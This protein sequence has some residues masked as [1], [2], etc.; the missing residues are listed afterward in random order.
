LELGSRFPALFERLATL[1]SLFQSILSNIV[2]KFNPNNRL[3]THDM[4]LTVGELLIAYYFPLLPMTS[5][6]RVQMDM[7]T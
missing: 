4:D 2:D 7:R 6:G 3:G 5:M 1:P